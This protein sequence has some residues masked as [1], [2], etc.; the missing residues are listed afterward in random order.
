MRVSAVRSQGLRLHTRLF[1]RLKPGQNCMDVHKQHLAAGVRGGPNVNLTDA[2]VAQK[3]GRATHAGRKPLTERRIRRIE[4]CKCFRQGL[5]VVTA[6]YD[7][8]D[9]FA[10]KLTGGRRRA[11]LA[12]C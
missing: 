9:P 3:G 8:T 5:P 11:P 10:V 7:E 6:A 1:V 2:N 4:C 12:P